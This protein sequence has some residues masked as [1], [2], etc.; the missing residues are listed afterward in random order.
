[1]VANSKRRIARGPDSVLNQ[2]RQSLVGQIW[3][4]ESLGGGAPVIL[5]NG[6]QELSPLLLQTAGQN[7][8]R[9]AEVEV[10]D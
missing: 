2:P 5:G 8:D 7:D 6:G 4:S 9:A 3:I 1:M 10:S